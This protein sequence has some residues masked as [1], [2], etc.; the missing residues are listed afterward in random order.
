MEDSG[1]RYYEF[2][3]DN[4]WQKHPIMVFMDLFTKYAKTFAIN[5]TDVETIVEIYVKE[6]VCWYGTSA[7]YYWIEVVTLLEMFLLE[8][9]KD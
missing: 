1:N 9:M 3:T 5:K 6:I 8:Y 7:N 4:T 2:S